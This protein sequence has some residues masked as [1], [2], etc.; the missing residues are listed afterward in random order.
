[1]KTLVIAPHPDDELLGCGGTLLRRIAEGGTVGW[2]LMTA[3]SE[4]AGWLP[5]K[6]AERAK[7]IECI[8]QG[9]GIHA[10]HFFSLGFPAAKLDRIPM[11]TLVSQVGDIFKKFQPQ[12]ILLPF[13]GDVHSDHRIT[14][15]AAC[16][17]VKWF[18]YPSVKRVLAYETP[19]E[20]DFGIDPRNSG[21]KPNFYVDISGFIELKIKLMA[22]YKSEMEDFPFPRSEKAL[23]A[24]AITRGSQAG[25]KEAESFM[26]LNQI[27]S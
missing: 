20:T 26:L 16:A 12:E 25:L 21:F 7:E 10:N 17:C 19:S 23:K 27:E 4:D 22:I 9:L 15:E 24:L 11:E 8:Q 6:V 13:P 1:M 14:F 3:I 5:E 2:L 18:R